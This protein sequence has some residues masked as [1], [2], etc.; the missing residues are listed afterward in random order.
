MHQD[1]LTIIQFLTNVNLNKQIVKVKAAG[2]SMVNLLDHLE[3]DNCVVLDDFDPVYCRRDQRKIR[4]DV[5]L[6]NG[7]RDELTNR[8]FQ[9]LFAQSKQNIKCLLENSAAIE[10]EDTKEFRADDP[11]VKRK[12]ESQLRREELIRRNRENNMF[13][14]REGL[15]KDT[16]SPAT[17]ERL[18]L[19][20]QKQGLKYLDKD[21]FKFMSELKEKI[22]DRFNKL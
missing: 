18:K 10:D 17:M 13:Q 9:G 3:E 16:G 6:A 11:R 21:E 2:A 5:M 20:K 14:I 19:I 7:I 8:E 4:R 22:N 1:V 15:W 12:N